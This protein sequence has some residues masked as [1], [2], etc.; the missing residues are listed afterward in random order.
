[1][2]L[3]D[4][5]VSGVMKSVLTEGESGAMPDVL[6]RLLAGTD[7]GSVRG[8][9]EQLQQGGLDRQVA[10]WLGNGSNLPIS[11]DELRQSLGDGQLRQLAKAAG[12][13]IDEL[14]AALS[15]QLPGAV[16]QMSPQGELEEATEEATDE[17]AGAEAESDDDASDDDTGGD[18]TGGSLADQA[19]L[20]DIRR[21]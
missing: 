20:N 19:G 7:L 17:A 12:L 15:Q 2:G 18:D 5:I 6:S 16:D 21:R 4:N 14:L 11:V 8:L 1:M 10:S 13:P 9:L 3:L